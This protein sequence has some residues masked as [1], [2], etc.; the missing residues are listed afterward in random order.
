MLECVLLGNINNTANMEN[1]STA[2]TSVDN[3]NVEVNVIVTFQG[4]ASGFNEV[5]LEVVANVMYILVLL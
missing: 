1:V 4:A 3:A 5:N 2:D